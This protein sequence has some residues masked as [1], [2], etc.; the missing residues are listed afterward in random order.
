MPDAQRGTAATSRPA[1][2]ARWARLDGEAL[3]AED[4]VSDAI[5]EFT[6]AIG[7]ERGTEVGDPRDALTEDELSKQRAELLGFVRCQREGE[8]L[9]GVVPRK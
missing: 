9:S 4:S 2:R 5:G 8:E 7:T 3:S 1:R 6:A